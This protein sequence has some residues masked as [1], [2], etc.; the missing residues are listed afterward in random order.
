MTASLLRPEAPELL[1][2]EATGEPFG[3]GWTGSPLAVMDE[4]VTA[5]KAV[6]LDQDG[7]AD[8]LTVSPS[9]LV[10]WENVAGE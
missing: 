1:L 5:V 2:W 6:D 9:M 3:G 10:L 4:H 7:D 8:L